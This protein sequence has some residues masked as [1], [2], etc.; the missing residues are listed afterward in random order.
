MSQRAIERIAR[1]VRARYGRH[2]WLRCAEITQELVTRLRIA[3]FDAKHVYGAIH[4][5]GNYANEYGHGA[6]VWADEGEPVDWLDHHWAQ[7]GDVIIDVSVDQFN[8]LM[9]PANK[10]RAV[11]IGRNLAFHEAIEELT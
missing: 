8:P 2:V 5:E 1:S 9:R 6:I 4:V 7:V 3:G 11:T 10:F